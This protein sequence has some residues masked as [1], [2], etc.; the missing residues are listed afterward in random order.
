MQP[1]S[2]KR[3]WR[4]PGVS[5]IWEPRA[6]WRQVTGFS[7]TVNSCCIQVTWRLLHIFSKLSWN[8]QTLFWSFLVWEMAWEMVWHQWTQVHGSYYVPVF[9]PGPGVSH[10][11][12]LLLGVTERPAL[13]KQLFTRTDQGG[14]GGQFGMNSHWECWCWGHKVWWPNLRSHYWV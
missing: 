8:Q 6:L 7:N 13:S 2:G 4:A 14:S 12:F 3:S 10:R 11:T 9:L 1:F 5:F